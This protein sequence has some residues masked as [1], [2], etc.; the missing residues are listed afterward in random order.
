MTTYIDK[1]ISTTIP[2][3]SKFPNMHNLVKKLQSH[4]HRRYCQRR[5][6][7]RFNFP[8]KPCEKTCLLSAVELG[9]N[10]KKKFYETKRTSSDTMIN[11]Y[12]PIILQHW[13]ANM[14]IRMVGGPFGIACYNCNY[15]CK[16]EP[17]TLKSA[18]SDLLSSLRVQQPPKP[19]RERMF[20]VGMCVL[21][22]RTMSAQEAAYRLSDLDFTSSTRETVHLS[23]LPPYKQYRKLRT[24]PEIEALNP[25]STNIF[26]SNIEDYHNRPQCL[27]NICL[28]R[29]AKCYK[30]Q[31]SKSKKDQLHMK[32]LNSCH[33]FKRKN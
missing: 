12:N 3:E 9:L 10:K 26:M 22:H 17:D 4:S 29:Y 13:K 30:K 27:E 33:F 32:L 19:I 14:D 15:I 11:P 18:L 20:T 25:E 16:S 24:K 28:F 2:D 23:A 5:G 6:K 1:V 31:Y 21:K 8:Y 7:C